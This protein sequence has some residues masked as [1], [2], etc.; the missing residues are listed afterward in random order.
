MNHLRRL[1]LTYSISL[2]ELAQAAGVSQQRI[3]EL[4]LNLLQRRS[5]ELK[6]RMELAFQHIIEARGKENQ[7]LAQDFERNRKRLFELCERTEDI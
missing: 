7:R 3:S 4:E 1:R 5:D 6:E 2:L